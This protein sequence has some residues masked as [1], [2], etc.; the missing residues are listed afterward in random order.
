MIFK[1]MPDSLH[2]L[3]TCFGVKFTKISCSIVIHF[4]KGNV[5]SDGD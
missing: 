5:A 2:I 1:S 3:V 4:S